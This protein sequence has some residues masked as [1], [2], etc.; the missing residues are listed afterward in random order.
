MRPP[1]DSGKWDSQ[2]WG[3]RLR[4]GDK[5]PAE[6]RDMANGGEGGGCVPRKDFLRQAVLGHFG[7]RQP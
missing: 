1:S 2:A 4:R 7:G 5:R 6:M 3:L